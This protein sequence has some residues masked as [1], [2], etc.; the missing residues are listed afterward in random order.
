MKPTDR[1]SPL[2]SRPRSDDALILFAKAPI[3][4]Q[5]KTRLCPP[6]TDDE[7]ASLHGSFVLDALERSGQAALRGVASKAPKFDRFLACAPSSDHVFF[8]IMEERHGVHVIDQ[9]GDDLGARMEHALSALFRLGYG[10][11]VIVGTDLPALPESVYEEAFD[12]LARHDLVLGPSLDGG[13]YLIGLSRTAPELFR[14]VPWSTPDVLT[15]TQAKA[16]ALGL[17]AALLT[18]QRD[19]DTIDDLRVLIQE[20]ESVGAP[21]PGGKGHKAKAPLLSKRTAGALQLIG[22]RLKQRD[23][24]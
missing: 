15:L 8:K 22:S 4:G 7:A 13:Y 9:I 18:P 21:G 3:P 2:G 12:L 5:V 10:R 24:G 11:A 14:G 17:N 23:P 16:H 20:A 6:L 1:S 19:V